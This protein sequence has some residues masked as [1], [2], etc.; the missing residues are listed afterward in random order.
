MDVSFRHEGSECSGTEPIPV[1]AEYI[2]FCIVT[3]TSATTHL[4]ATATAGGL[5]AVSLVRWTESI[6]QRVWKALGMYVG[7]RNRRLSNRAA[8]II[9]LV[10]TTRWE[11]GRRQSRAQNWKTLI[12]WT[13][14]VT[15]RPQVHMCAKHYIFFS[16]EINNVQSLN[17]NHV[18]KFGVHY[19]LL[20]YFFRNSSL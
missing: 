2:V 18:I 9:I 19:Y 5:R 13:V 12:Y 8:W 4:T 1:P 15:R 3:N 6:E 11:F 14:S 7:T 20:K 10:R 17:L 16:W